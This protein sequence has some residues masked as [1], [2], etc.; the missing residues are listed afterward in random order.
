MRGVAME[1]E[2]NGKVHTSTM[3]RERVPRLTPAGAR[4]RIKQA[5]KG[6]IR[7]EDELY[8]PKRETTSLKVYTDGQDSFTRDDVM[9]FKNCS[10]SY[11]IDCL[12]WWE[13][14]EITKAELKSSKH[15]NPNSSIAKTSEWAAMGNRVR[16]THLLFENLPTKLDREMS[17]YPTVN[18]RGGISTATSQVVGNGLH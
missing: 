8:A 5:Q 10:P 4:H 17:K 1:C 15:I 13:A 11:A 2:I 7:T 6:I 12:N 14:G 16:N 9:K 3:V 18:H